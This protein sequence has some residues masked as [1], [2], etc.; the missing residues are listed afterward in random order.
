MTPVEPASYRTLSDH[1]WCID[2]QQLREQLAACYLVGDGAHYAFIECGTNH[3]VPQLLALLDHLGIQREQVRYVIPTHVHLDHAG[4]AGLLMQELPEATLV[5]HPRGARHMVDPS[6]LWKGVCAVYGDDEAERMY[7]A[8]I[9]V[10]E[11]RVRI[12]D[13]GEQIA[14]GTRVLDVLDSP[15]HARHHFSLWDATTRGW[16]TGDTFGLSYREFDSAYGAFVI[17]T[18]TPVQFDPDAWK[19]TL[20]AYLARDPACM[21]LTHFCRVEDV[22]RLADDLRTA[23]DDYVTI[24]RSL[25]DSHHR[26]DAIVDALS[27]HA[28]GAAQRHAAP[29]SEQAVRE[30][31]AHDIE[32]NAQGL[33][34]WLDREAA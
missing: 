29:L 9:P 22:Q 28:V 31:L 6:A 24:A 3:S 34:V 10:P 16:F 20:D 21:Y 1:L 15:G 25:K 5:M 12:A 4:G 26:H 7:G 18:T 13:S 32:L 17:P 11:E 8:L 23:I 14:V 27:A 2:T 33:E 19:T 30:L